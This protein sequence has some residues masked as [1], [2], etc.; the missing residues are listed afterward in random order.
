MSVLPVAHAGHWIESIV[1]LVPIVG[2]GLWL[3]ITTY[4][5]KRRRREEGDPD[6]G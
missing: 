5:D 6:A 3:G 1:Y 4:R 2:F